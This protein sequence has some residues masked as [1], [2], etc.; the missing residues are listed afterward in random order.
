[1]SI[2]FIEWHSA[3][4]LWG[5]AGVALP[6]VAHLLSRRG[7]RPVSLPTA[8][9]L[10]L[11]HA[12]RGRRLRL[13]QW[14]LL[15]LRIAIIALIALAF[16][17]PQWREGSRQQLPQGA[18]EIV[19]VLDASASTA[20]HGTGASYFSLAVRRAAQM[21]DG[22]DTGDHAAVVVAG[23]SAEPIL[24]RLSENIGALRDR[25][26]GLEP[27]VGSANLADAVRLARRL[28]SVLNSA[29]T[30]A[31]PSVREVILLTDGQSTHIDDLRSLAGEAGA[32]I[33]RI[34]SIGDASSVGNLALTAMAV[35]PPRPTRGG[36]FLIHANVTNHG[37]QPATVE[38]RCE[39]EP[40]L[41]KSPLPVMVSVEP[42]A[43]A[44]ATV[45]CRADGAGSYRVRLTLPADALAADD[46]LQATVD[47]RRAMQVAILSIGADEPRS[48]A[49]YLDAALRP[50]DDSPYEVRT[51]D[52]SRARLDAVD[53]S[54][55]DAVI[56]CESGQ[57]SLEWL[58]RID[59]FVRGGGALWWFIDSV[60]AAAAT[61]VFSS[62][63]SGGP[64]LPLVVR[65]LADASTN[66]IWSSADPTHEA[67][68]S[69]DG[70]SLGSLQGVRHLRFA[71][72]VTAPG[73]SELIRAS[74]GAPI[75]AVAA[76]ESGR[77]LL[78]NGSIDRDAS[79]FTRQPLFP[80]LVHEWMSWLTG[81]AAT[82]ATVHPGPAAF[83]ELQPGA[84]PS[85]PL[86][87]E[88]EQPFTSIEEGG[89]RLV[90]IDRVSGVGA[91]D[92]FDA[93]KGAWLGG[94]SVTIDP[95][96]SS[97]D[98][99]DEALIASL[100]STASAG[101]DAGHA[102]PTPMNSAL[103]VPGRRV[104]L[105][106]WLALLAALAAGVESA[107]ALAATRREVGA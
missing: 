104:E 41:S 33:L 106:P 55:L 49:S 98:R 65:D 96:E 73:A 32:S 99:A 66:A 53:W 43:T 4:M 72:L 105:W 39:F 16:A 10:A 52:P 59:H 42:G 61:D 84:A 97:M 20:R 11:A 45:R 24:P 54:R 2:A 8:R 91:I 102:P 88:P 89:R 21:L 25:L 15:A 14:A 95:R 82:M 47:V 64:G 9:F 70:P 81:R 40:R 36:E 12:Q 30:P 13:A 68:A 78:F 86:R 94:A 23:V 18:R 67:L 5:L 35:S 22:L 93:D 57:L 83:I 1:M 103:P 38:L 44:T 31:G 80:A 60:E 51:F 50:D 6:L 90:R 63:N 28:P 101:Q 74:D 87:V 19:L 34:E 29:E 77:S 79:E 37:S 92:V 100:E 48:T 3:A 7:S 71:H 76:V 58:G 17:R 69:F 85:R 62:L 107:V 27:G 75:V 26:A 56:L 46:T